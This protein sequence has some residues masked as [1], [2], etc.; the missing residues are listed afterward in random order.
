LVS[1]N[2][3]KRL[4]SVKFYD[5]R[6]AHLLRDEDVVFEHRHCVV[7]FGPTDK[8]VD[9]K[10]PPNN[11]T[12]VVFGLG[13]GVTND[14]VEEVFEGFGEIREVRDCPGKPKQRFVEFWDQRAAASALSVLSH[15]MV[16][17]LGGRIEIQFSRPGGFRL[18]T[19]ALE[20]NSVPRIEGR[21]PPAEITFS[22]GRKRT[23]NCELEPLSGD[24][25]VDSCGI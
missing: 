7:A 5:L 13:A 22:E 25:A 2:V 16:Q 14:T 4:A 15:Q 11:G 10:R 20:G 6:S 19:T 1:L 3:T 24:L 12:I 23:E 17:K 8:V 18:T 9:K 21:P